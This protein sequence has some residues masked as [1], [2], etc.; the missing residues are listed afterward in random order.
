[1][2]Q[3]DEVAAMIRLHGLGWVPSGWRMSSDAR[4][5][6]RRYLR[7]GGWRL[8]RRLVRRSALDGPDGWLRERVFRHSGNAD[9]IRQELA[10]EHGLVLSLRHGER[11]VTGWRRELKAL[12]PEILHGRVILRKGDQCHAPAGVSGKR[13]APALCQVLAHT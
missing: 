2:L 8:S 10:T 4:N 5:T 13:A 12:A 9:V 6:V 11:R 3:P 7:Q 1:M